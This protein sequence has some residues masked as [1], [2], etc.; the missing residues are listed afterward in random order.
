MLFNRGQMYKPYAE[1][2]FN[3]KSIP[4][5]LK[6]YVT[7]IEIEESD[8]ETDMAKVT[9]LDN[10]FKFSNYVK[11]LIDQKAEVYI[12]F[13][14]KKIVE[15]VG[16]VSTIE[17]DF[18]DDGSNTL[19]I[20][21]LDNTVYFTN[22]KRTR[23]WKD[24]RASDIA[25]EI[26]KSYGFKYSI[27]QTS[28]VYDEYTQ[29]DET[30]GE[31]LQ[32]LAED[33]GLIFYWIAKENKLYFGECIKSPQNQGTL[34]Y[35]MKDTDIISFQPQLVT[36]DSPNLVEVSAGEVS[37]ST[38]KTYRTELKAKVDTSSHQYSSQGTSGT[39]T[40]NERRR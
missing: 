10:D 39:P 19:I 12:G 30:D 38:G 17:G 8:Y 40:V 4:D 15:V 21:V 6:R 20:T 18:A 28:T 33:E 9:V 25:I 3:G 36:K 31:L 5:D 37:A 2:K 13:Q 7:N 32:K 22:T 34:Y 16:K 27:P 26:A 1:F 29:D 23:K 14:G 24:K 35:K 11:L